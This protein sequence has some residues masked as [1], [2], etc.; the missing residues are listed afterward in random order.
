[1]V[2]KPQ[3]ALTEEV[4]SSEKAKAKEFVLPGY[5]VYE[6]GISAF[7]FGLCFLSRRVLSMRARY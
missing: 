4:A 1:M 7:V 5:K 3:G 2:S 6:R